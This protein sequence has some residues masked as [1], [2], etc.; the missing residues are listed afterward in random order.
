M[1]SLLFTNTRHTT[2]NCF[3]NY[4]QVASEY[5]TLHTFVEGPQSIAMSYTISHWW[6][7]TVLTHL[8]VAFTHKHVW[9][10]EYI[11]TLQ[12]SFVTNT[13]RTYIIIVLSLK[14]KVANHLLQ[15]VQFLP[16][17]RLVYHHATWFHEVMKT[18]D[19][20]SF[21]A[22]S[23]IFQLKYVPNIPVK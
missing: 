3:T 10:V 4:W 8:V 6:Q 17:L 13:N 15:F 23:K 1:W 2:N 18:R 7:S 9:L 11:S 14:I 16:G 21:H 5:R 19:V 12:L 20:T 22:I